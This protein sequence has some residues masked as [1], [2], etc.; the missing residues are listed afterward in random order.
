MASR[1]AAVDEPNVNVEGGAF[2]SAVGI[3]FAVTRAFHAGFE[4]DY[5]YLAGIDTVLVGEHQVLFLARI[6]FAFG[7]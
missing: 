1:T 7:V 2:T 5:R 4:V 3:D 6:G